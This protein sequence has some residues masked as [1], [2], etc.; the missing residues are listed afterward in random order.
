V[1]VTWLAGVMSGDVDCH[2]RPWFLT[3]HELNKT[4]PPSDSLRRRLK[5]HDQ[6][7]QTVS[8]RLS[9][10]RVVVSTEVPLHATISPP[11]VKL[12]G[13]VDIAADDGDIVLYECKTGRVRL[14]DQYQLLIYSYLWQQVYGVRASRLVVVYPD[15]EKVVEPLATDFE[16]RLI[17]TLRGLAGP[18]P[19]SRVPGLECRYCPI[20][21]VDCIERLESQEVP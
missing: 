1:W 15:A 11:G 14:S 9:Q 4:N 13:S 19:L 2:W 16:T 3:Q 18:E 17:T 10:Q 8:A 6:L 21:R 5:Q 12:S 20:T 7:V